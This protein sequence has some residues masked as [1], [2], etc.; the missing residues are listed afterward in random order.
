MTST[1]QY[2]IDNIKAPY[3]HANSSISG[4]SKQNSYFE[5]TITNNHGSYTAGGEIGII[6]ASEMSITVTYHS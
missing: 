1:N 5:F 4:I 3:A 6:G 2:T